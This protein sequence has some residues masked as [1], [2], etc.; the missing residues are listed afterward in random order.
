MALNLDKFINNRS[1]KSCMVVGDIILDKYVYGHVDRISPEAPIPVVSTSNTKYVLGGAANVAGNIGG[2]GLNAILCGVIGT[3]TEGDE[4]VSQLKEKKV[5]FEGYR[6]P[7]RCTTLKTRVVGMNQQLVRVDREDASPLSSEEEDGLII[8]IKDRLSSVD[9]LVLSD[10]NKGVCTDSFCKRLFDLCAA[11]GKKIVVDPKSSNWTKYKGAFVITPN[12]K[13]FRE[14]IGCDIPN[15]ERNISEKAADLLDRYELAQILVT[16]SQYGMTLVGMGRDAL[17]FKAKQQEVFDVSGAGDTVIAT[18]TSGLSLGYSIEEAVEISNY[19]AGV[20]V[21]K[22]GTYV[23]TLEDLVEYINGE[24][25]WYEDKIVRFDDV[26]KL[27]EKWRGLGE[28]IVFTNGCFDIMHIGHIDYLNRARRL[29]TKLIVGLNSDASVKRLKG[30]KRPINGEQERALMLAALQCVDAVVIFD[31]DTPE[32]L[33][34]KVKPDYLVKGG[35]YAIESIVGRQFAGE[36]LTI[37]LTE[38]FSTTSMIEKIK[39]M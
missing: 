4:L 23:V 14:A 39:E 18:L 29:G 35:D 9:Y 22:A 34:S 3:D 33:I 31:T 15:D 11:E 5:A 20:A 25:A 24:G 38:G 16:R 1:G 19:A 27:I 36:T 2:L 17:T 21:S 30:E 28:R 37:P 8:K 12:F 32:E 26:T 10:Y 7:G 13:E 6:S